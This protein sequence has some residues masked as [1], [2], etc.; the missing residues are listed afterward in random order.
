METVS[1]VREHAP[2]VPIVVL[3]G[4]DDEAA[5]VARRAGRGRRTTWSRARWTARCWCARC[6]TPSS[7]SALEAERLRL[8]ASERTARAE[9]E[10][11]ASERAA[12]LRHIADAVIIADPCGTVVYLNEAAYELLGYRVDE[13]P[14]PSAW[15]LR[16]SAD[17]PFAEDERPLVRAARRGETLAKIDHR[18]HHRN[19]HVSIV[20]GSAAPV[21]TEDGGGLGRC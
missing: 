15:P 17:R 1:R 5:R 2:G 4:L 19:G 20:E 16:D 14:P 9:A 3:S 8:L 13:L 10:R 7:A 12:I 6:A 21:D 11:L 18:A